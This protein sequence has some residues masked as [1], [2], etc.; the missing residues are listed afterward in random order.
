M[1]KQNGIHAIRTGWLIQA[2]PRYYTGDGRSQL[3]C[4]TA[5]PQLAKVYRRKRWAHLMADTLDE[6]HAMAAQLG[7]E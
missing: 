3:E 4:W 2:G 5:F 7:G 1:R 6:L